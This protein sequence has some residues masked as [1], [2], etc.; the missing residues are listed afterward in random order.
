MKITINERQFNQLILERH[1]SDIMYH[2]TPLYKLPKILKSDMLTFS[3]E[4]GES[5]I[6]LTTIKSSQFGYPYCN[7]SR[8]GGVRS[9]ARLTI[10][11]RKLQYN[12]SGKRFQFFKNDYRQS[13]VK[14][15][16][17]YYRPEMSYDEYKKKNN[18]SGV[19]YE[20][21]F[22]PEAQHMEDYES[23]DRI[24]RNKHEKD[25]IRPIKP[26]IVRIDIFLCGDNFNRDIAHLYNVKENFDNSK[27]FI[28]DNL[29]YFDMQSSKKC[30]SI[31]EI[32]SRQL[33]NDLIDGLKRIFF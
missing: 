9:F 7:Y 21:N 12:H 23:E 17:R 6:S 33:D 18:G 13:S 5:F 8:M 1:F 20:S 2:F 15:N 4:D 22:N 10:D 27:I 16:P 14:G 31:D 11:G 32:L 3:N 19:G 29:K 25:G 30:Y 26:Y 24:M 28:Y